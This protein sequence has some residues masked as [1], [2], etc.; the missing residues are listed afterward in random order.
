MVF[1]HF[2]L[3]ENSI[4]FCSGTRLPV[5]VTSAKNRLKLF[6]ATSRS[7]NS[8]DFNSLSENPNK[9]LVAG[10]QDN[11]APYSLRVM[12]ASTILSSDWLSSILWLSSSTL[13]LTCSSSALFARLVQ[14]R[15]EYYMFVAFLRRAVTDV[16]DPDISLLAK[17]K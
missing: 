14:Q 4:A 3:P 17:V 5:L 16:L 9:E 10:L 2:V 6:G 13:S 7:V 8:I 15:S 11:R 12:T 1:P